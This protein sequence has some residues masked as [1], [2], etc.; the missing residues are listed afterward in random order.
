M[1]AFPYVAILLQKSAE[2]RQVAKKVA[3][4]GLFRVLG[5]LGLFGV[6]L[7]FWGL[8]PR[9]K[10]IGHVRYLTLPRVLYCT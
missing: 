9:W 5:S 2:S 6:V 8:S 3:F 10:A 4:V 1:V 7:G